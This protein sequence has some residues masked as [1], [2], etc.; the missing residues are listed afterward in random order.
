MA[1]QKKKLQSIN[2]HTGEVIQEFVYL[3]DEELEKKMQLAERAFEKYRDTSFEQRAQWM[4][5]A[6]DLLEQNGSKFGELVTKEMGR[7]Y[8]Q[9]KEEAPKCAKW[10]RWYAKNAAGILKEVSLKT[11]SGKKTLVI[12]EP[13]GVLFQIAPFNYPYLQCLRFLTAALMAGN[14]AVI[15][16]SHNTTL[17]A[18]SIEKLFRDAG[19]PE[20]VCQILLIGKEQSDKLIND[21]RIKGVAITGSVE[22][23]RKVA[24][25]AGNALKKQVME[26]GGSDAYIICQDADME[27]AVKEAVKGRLVNNGQSCTAAKRFIVVESKYQNFCDQLVKKFKEVKMGDPMNEENELGPLA[28]KDLRDKVHEAVEKSVKAGAKLLRRVHS[29]GQRFLL[30]CHCIGRCH[31]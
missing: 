24:K 2:P 31:S 26:L 22:A 23:G 10:A 8:K 18:L 13:M 17:A 25:Q 30:S 7:V 19:F 5:N 21:S 11:N 4:N 15:K 28:R 16:H 9:A 1:S 27:L 29:R 6:A 3:S 20:G 14:V 12:Y